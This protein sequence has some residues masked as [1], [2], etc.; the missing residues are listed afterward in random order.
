MPARPQLIEVH[1]RRREQRLISQ[2]GI[3]AF[4]FSCCFIVWLEIDGESLKNRGSAS[5]IRACILQ[6][7]AANSFCE[8]EKTNWLPF[9][10]KG[11]E[12]PS[13]PQLT[14]DE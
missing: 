8:A 14:F 1:D 9:K 12:L 3:I 7:T 10:L 13:L 11:V 4:I 6:P 5:S 2:E